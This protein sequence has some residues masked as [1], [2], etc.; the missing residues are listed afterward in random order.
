MC[1]FSSLRIYLRSFHR[2]VVFAFCISSHCILSQ[3]D[4]F[5][6]SSTTEKLLLLRLATTSGLTGFK[7]CTHILFILFHPDQLISLHN[8]AS[9]NNS[10]HWPLSLMPNTLSSS[11]HTT[12]CSLSANEAWFASSIQ[13]KDWRGPVPIPSLWQWINQQKLLGFCSELNLNLTTSHQFCFHLGM[14][15]ASSSPVILP[16]FLV[17]TSSSILLK[18]IL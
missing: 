4:F 18:Q 16:Y 13:V 12:L 1:Q 7:Y 6:I 15:V 14:S 17:C 9:L 8:K 3:S 2:S 11:S 5:F 10:Q